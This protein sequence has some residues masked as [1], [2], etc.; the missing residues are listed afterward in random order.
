MKKNSFFIKIYIDLPKNHIKMRIRNISIALFCFVILTSCKNEKNSENNPEVATEVVN[1]FL[2][3]TLDVTVKKDDNF[4]IYYIDKVTEPFS[5]EKSVWVEVK[6]NPNPQK[7]VFNIPQNQ[8]PHLLRLDFGLNTSQEDIV[9]SGLELN[10]FGKV[11]IIRGNEL[12][13]IL[14]PVSPTKINFE[15]GIINAKDENGKRVEPSLY[16]QEVPFGQELDKLIK[17]SN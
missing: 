13:F 1:D 17:T 4:Q 14:R 5:E 15:T 10:Y 11:K 2:K 3:V 6:G 7:V 12:A 9:F 16:P 8:A